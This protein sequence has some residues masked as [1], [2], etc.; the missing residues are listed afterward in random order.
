MIVAKSFAASGGA[1][2]RVLV[3][4]CGFCGRGRKRQIVACVS[5][6][7]TV[8]RIGADD[9]LLRL[10][11]Q[12]LIDRLS[13]LDCLRFL[14][15]RQV[16]AGMKIK[17]GLAGEAAPALIHPAMA[18]CPQRKPHAHNRNDRRRAAV[19]CWRSGKGV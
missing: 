11:V 9:M 7:R 18:D 2:Y 12:L 1:L 19:P 5:A 15:G 13:P 16:R 17:N 10:Q 6:H 4:A 3:F 14:C 8:G